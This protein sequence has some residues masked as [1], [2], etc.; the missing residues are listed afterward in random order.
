MEEM[1]PEL[2]DLE[3]RG[4][5]NKLEIRSIVRKRRDFEYALKRRAALK[6]DFLKY[7][8]YEQGLERLRVIRKK[9][10]NIEGK[11]T[12]ADMCFVRRVH[13][14][15]ERALRKD[16]GD[17]GLWAAW[18]D[19]CKTSNSG[20]KASAVLARALQLHPTSPALWARSAAWE[21]ER[22]ANA[23]A[24]RA[25]MQQGLRMCKDAPGLWH[26]YFRMELLYALR[27]QERRKILGINTMT[28][29]I[30]AE[31][32]L[33]GAV[34]GVVYKNAI[35]SVNKSNDTISFRK[36]FLDILAPYQFI[37][38]KALGDLI[39]HSIEQDYP[40]NP[41]AWD[42]KAR[43][44]YSEEGKTDEETWQ[45]TLAV[46]EE[47]IEVAPSIHMYRCLLQFLEERLIELGV[48]NME[49]EPLELR[50]Q[51]RV[52]ALYRRALRLF[53]ES[54]GLKDEELLLQWPR[55][56]LRI[57]DT[58]QAIQA[59]QWACE[60]I[61]HSSKIWEQRLTLEALVETGADDGGAESSSSDSDESEG[62][63]EKQ[64]PPFVRTVQQALECVPREDRTGVWMVSIRLVAALYPNMVPT[65][66]VNEMVKQQCG[67]SKGGVHGGMGA[68]AAALIKSIYQSQGINSSRA[69]YGRLLPLPSPGSD[70]FHMILDIELAQSKDQI[71]LERVFEAAVSSHGNEDERLWGRWLRYEHTQHRGGGQIY[72][73]AVETL[74]TPEGFVHHWRHA[75][76]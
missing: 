58:R 36:K 64:V 30:A 60:A 20:K 54:R 55:A 31:A 13:F 21:F 42:L 23:V 5:F 35:V 15:F 61:P 52:L 45:S 57:G 76:M 9:E 71:E 72:W 51:A 69:A 17:L 10:R 6:R 43:R 63:T 22:N 68:V 27:L 40:T 4:Y 59:A 8:Q 74:D 28:E 7:I 53:E 50:D 37:G 73:R 62:A 24:A 16:R 65:V 18:L 26:E 29:D 19:Y 47:G 41:L 66:L 34:A 39:F 44:R 70:F 75:C 25:L 1:V 49:Q 2:E 67:A 3:Q 12:L 48:T 38:K 46:Y 33:Q 32:V 56:C 11:P 14:I